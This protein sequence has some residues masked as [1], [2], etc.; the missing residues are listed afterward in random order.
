[1]DHLNKSS[2][3]VYIIHM[4][5]LGFIAL[6]MIHLELA[7]FIKFVLLTVL[8][9]SIS[10]AIVIA[11]HRWFQ[12]NM[13]LRLGTFTVLFVALFAFIR[14]GNKVNPVNDNVLL[15]VSQTDVMLPAMGIHE[16][17]IT[18]NME[19]VQQYI[20]VGADLDEKDPMGGSS[21]LITAAVFGKT[22]MALALINAGADVNFKNHEGSTPLH[23]AAF[24]CRT[25]IVEVLLAKGADVNIKNNAGSTAWNAVSGPFES[26]KGIYDYFGKAYGPMGLELD[27]EQLKTTRPVIAAMIKN[28]TSE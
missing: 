19:V 11:Y 18:G 12:H 16:A 27:D 2:Y 9:Y 5:V 15:P 10:N 8:S 20:N 14:F 4:I 24:F 21:P 6:A 26:V 28:Q 22:E 13:S 23:T 25:A 17:V 3:Q 1:M 7:G